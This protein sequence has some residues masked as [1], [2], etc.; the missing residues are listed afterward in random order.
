MSTNSF[1]PALFKFLSDLAANNDRDWFNANKDR[2][3]ETVQEPALD[4]ITDFAPRLKRISPHFAADARVQGGSLFRIYR[5]TRFGADKTPYKT[6]TGVQFR[7][8]VAKDA[9][10]PGFYLH[11]QPREC[12]MGVGLWRPQAA[13]ANE[14]RQHIVDEPGAW[15]RAAHGKRFTDVYALDGDSLKRPPRGFDADHALIE[16][17]MRKDFIAS[18]RLTQKEVTSAD[19]MDLFDARCRAAGPFMKFLCQA[20]DLPY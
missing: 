6:N 10:A 3:I 12:F 17:L 5:D 1:T 9:H 11:L 20:V 15:K 13:T 2:Y 14:I 4:F 18:A 16:D 19:F 7:H 8:E